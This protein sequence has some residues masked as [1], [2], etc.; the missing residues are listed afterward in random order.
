MLI[1]FH[2]LLKS[3]NIVVLYKFYSTITAFDILPLICFILI[4]QIH[5]QEDAKSFVMFHCWRLRKSQVILIWIRME[6][7]YHLQLEKVL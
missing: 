5:L 3:M 6:R 1:P 4:L 7:V 2:V